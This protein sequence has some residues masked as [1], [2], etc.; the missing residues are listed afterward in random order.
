MN[1]LKSMGNTVNRLDPQRGT[2]LFSELRYRILNLRMLLALLVTVGLVFLLLKRVSFD[3]LNESLGAVS[4]CWWLVIGSISLVYPFLVAKRWS[5]VLSCMRHQLPMIRCILLV[6]ASF[7]INPFTISK[8]GDFLKAFFLRKRMSIWECS[9]SIL[10][11]KYLDIMT[12][13]ILGLFG[14]I[15]IWIPS[16]VMFSGISL[17]FLIGAFCIAPK[18]VKYFERWPRISE[19]IQG[20]MLARKSIATRPLMLTKVMM[21]SL[22]VRWLGFLQIFIIVNFLEMDISLT[23]IFAVFP[24]AICVGLLPIT[25]SGI[26]TRD[27]VLVMLLTHQTSDVLVL[28]IAYTLFNYLILS[29][30]GIPFLIWILSRKNIFQE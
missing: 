23:K 11:E 14:A 9:G 4:V 21:I 13:F 12:V 30:L 18:I 26:G 10:V 27:A 17:A 16:L 7:A 8:A 22:I 24:I 6:L 3:L 28:G 15:I 2:D 5:I 29:F 1:K 20:L 25:L 19:K